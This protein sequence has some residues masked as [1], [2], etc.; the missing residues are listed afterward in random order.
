MVPTAA[1]EPDAGKGGKDDKKKGG[2]D[3]KGKGKGKEE[4]VEAPPEAAGPPSADGK[5]ESAQ[6]A[7]AE[8]RALTLLARVESLRWKAIQV[9]LTTCLIGALSAA[10]G[11]GKR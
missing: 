9:R 2:K 1:T 4:V 7:E 8:T 6:R 11:K 5:R 3:D 10:P